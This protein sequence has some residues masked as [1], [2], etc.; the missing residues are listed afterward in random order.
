MGINYRGLQLE[1]ATGNQYLLF[2]K[3]VEIERTYHM[4]I[5]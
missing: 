5:K 4:C 1:A 2:K 3:I